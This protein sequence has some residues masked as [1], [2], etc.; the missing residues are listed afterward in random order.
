M[1]KI[2]AL[3]VLG[4]LGHE[5]RTQD[6]RMT[7]DP[8]FCVQVKERFGPLAGGSDGDGFCFYD[9]EEGV[10]VEKGDER[11][12][13]LMSQ[14]VC[15]ALPYHIQPFPYR[16]YWTTIQTCLTKAGA[17]RYLQDNGHN[18]QHYHGTRVY[19]DSAWRNQEVVDLRK[20]ILTITETGHE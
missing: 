9:A 16:S 6:N 8:V 10:E 14:H 17:D 1:D 2:E 20:A 11:F 18:L 4:K 19:V 15:G 3:I 7:R 12:Q 13:D 5:L